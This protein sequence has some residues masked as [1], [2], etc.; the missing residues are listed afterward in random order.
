MEF[1]KKEKEERAL[2]REQD[3]KELKEM[4]SQGVKNEVEA[5]MEPI[6]KKQDI[7]PCCRCY[8]ELSRTNQRYC[9][10]REYT[11]GSPS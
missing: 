4:I 1:M 8:C 2:E 3:K 10:R 11:S 7:R 5:S 6:I 9:N